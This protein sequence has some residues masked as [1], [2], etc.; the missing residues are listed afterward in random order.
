M[1]SPVAPAPHWLGA[2]LNRGREEPP[3][4]AGESSGLQCTHALPEAPAPQPRHPGAVSAGPLRAPCHRG[5]E[6]KMLPA[7]GPPG[8]HRDGRGSL[9]SHWP[10]GLIAC[11]HLHPPPWGLPGQKD[12]ITSAS[13]SLH[14]L[15]HRVPLTVS[16]VVVT[17]A[18]GS[19]T[20][21]SQLSRVLGNKGTE[22]CGLCI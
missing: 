9:C 12:L 10:P 8:T 5:S 20:P 18:S 2:F 3:G 16:G 4:G 21:H 13:L 14:G 19:L 17:P 15:L 22:C 11:A 1:S 6:V 7:R